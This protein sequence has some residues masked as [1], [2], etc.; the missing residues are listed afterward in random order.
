M[1]GVMVSGGQT[2]HN[3]EKDSV[4]PC[5]HTKKGK[6]HAQTKRNVNVMICHD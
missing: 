4:W 6:T 3:G 2:G 1:L 5:S